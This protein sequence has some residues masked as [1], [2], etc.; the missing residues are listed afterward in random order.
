MIGVF[1][2][3]FFSA[4][5]REDLEDVGYHCGHV[6]TYNLFVLSCVWASEVQRMSYF[7]KP[8]RNVSVH[9]ALTSKEN[10]DSVPRNGST[11]DNLT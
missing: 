3:Y 8:G 10:R 6:A 5:E 1:F 4:L 7:S 2:G 11:S 9:V